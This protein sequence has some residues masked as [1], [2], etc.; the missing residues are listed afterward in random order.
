M[1]F[2]TSCSCN[3]LKFAL[4]C[5]ESLTSADNFLKEFD[6]ATFSAECVSAVNNYDKPITP[7]L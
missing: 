4:L 5:I 6:Y 1:I 2:R 7:F 3:S